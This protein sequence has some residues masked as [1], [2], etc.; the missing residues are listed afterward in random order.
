VSKIGKETDMEERQRMMT[1][2]FTIHREE[3]GSIPLYQEPLV[4]AVRKGVEVPQAP[5]NKVRLWLVRMP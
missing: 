5:D 3:H 1:R 4:W 2:A